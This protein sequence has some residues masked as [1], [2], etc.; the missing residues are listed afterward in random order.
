MSRVLSRPM[1]RV[2]IVDRAALILECFSRATPELSLPQIAARLKLPKAT[3]FRILTNLVRLGLLD[4]NP[5]ANLYTL[6][7]GALRLADGLL[8]SLPIRERARPIMQ[9]IRDAVNES[10]VLSVREGDERYNIDSVESTHAIG[11][12]QQIG[13]PIPLYAGAASR[14]LLAALPDAEIAAYLSRAERVAFSTS[15]M[16]DAA[17]LQEEIARIRRRGYATSAGEFTAGG[18]AVACAVLSP[19]GQAAGA[20][21]VSIPKT[22]FTRELEARC[23]HELVAGARAIAQI[24]QKD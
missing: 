1:K 4:H 14:V 11:Q 22:R 24:L 19:E 17:R 2:G 16:T 3:A 7:F 18:H 20:I 6:G 12:T 13:V 8:L 9:A 10:V 23:A 5:S 15:T 21:H